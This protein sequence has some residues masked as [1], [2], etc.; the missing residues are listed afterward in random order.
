MHLHGL[1]FLLLLKCKIWYELQITD[2]IN[3]FIDSFFGFW[4]RAIGAIC[5]LCI[6][7]HFIVWIVI[8]LFHLSVF[9]HNVIYLNIVASGIG[10]RN[11][12]I[13]NISTKTIITKQKFMIYFLEKF[14]KKKGWEIGCWA[15]FLES[16]SFSLLIA[17]TSRISHVA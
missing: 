3:N 10:F 9:S 15:P 7:F 4:H 1:V 6:F 16:Q 11:Y 2:K 17:S 12:V 5:F 8:T 13:T 14:T